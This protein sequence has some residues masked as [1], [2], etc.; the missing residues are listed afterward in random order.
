MRKGYKNFIIRYIEL[1][2]NID[3]VGRL[4]V[5]TRYIS[6]YGKINIRNIGRVRDAIKKYTH[7][8]I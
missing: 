7:W 3:D 2:A 1:Q 4:Q 8:E 5:I 6:Q